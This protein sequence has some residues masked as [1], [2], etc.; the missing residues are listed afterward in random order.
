MEKKDIME[1][2]LDSNIENAFYFDDLRLT[3]IT[4]NC[5]LPCYEQILHFSSKLAD[6]PAQVKLFLLIVE[7]KVLSIFSEA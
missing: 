4:N 6:S 3:Q 2:W 7:N 5:C 1:P